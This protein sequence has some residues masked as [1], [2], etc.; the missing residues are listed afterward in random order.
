LNN[1]DLDKKLIEEQKRRDQ[2]KYWEDQKLEQ[3]R[4]ERDSQSIA[5]LV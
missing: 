2:Q 1:K 4:R 3:A 5:G